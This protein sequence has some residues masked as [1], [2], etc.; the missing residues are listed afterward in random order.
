MLLYL[1][2]SPVA[3]YFRGSRNYAR[4]LPKIIYPKGEGFYQ[5]EILDF[6]LSP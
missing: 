4:S 6:L 3:K 5:K 2:L 1:V